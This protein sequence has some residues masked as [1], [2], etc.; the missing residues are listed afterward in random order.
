MM[1]GLVTGAYAGLAMVDM[2]PPEMEWSG[3]DGRAGHGSLCWSTNFRC[4]RLVGV[5]SVHLCMGVVSVE[6]T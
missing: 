4:L 1:A 3:H 2:L 6:A 5:W